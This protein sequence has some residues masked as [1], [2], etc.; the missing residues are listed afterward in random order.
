MH[1][2]RTNLFV[3]GTIPKCATCTFGSSTFCGMDAQKKGISTLT[4]TQE[5]ILEN[6]N[7]QRGEE[8]KLFKY[9]QQQNTFW[10]L[11]KGDA[12]STPSYFS[13]FQNRPD[14]GALIL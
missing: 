11:K 10:V 13:V 6:V 4:S 7:V 9:V 12:K 2:Y 1:F 3:S 8:P 5:Q 14:R